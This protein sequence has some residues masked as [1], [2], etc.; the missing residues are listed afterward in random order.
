MAYIK[1]VPTNKGDREMTI[2][3]RVAL[4]NRMLDLAATEVAKG[5][6]TCKEAAQH[7][8]VDQAV[9]V[10]RADAKKKAKRG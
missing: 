6:M 7:F 1:T 2:T 4:S 3:S 5:T 8:C 9:L 10:H